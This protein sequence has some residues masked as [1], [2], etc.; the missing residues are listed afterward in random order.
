MNDT[1]D[2]HQLWSQLDAKIE[3]NWQLNLAL[4]KAG[5]LEKAARRLK[6]LVWVKASGLV[7]ALLFLAFVL[8]MAVLNWQVLS[9]ALAGLVLSI[10]TVAIIATTV[11][12]LILVRQIDFAA[13]V[14]SLQKDLSKLRLL[15]IRYLRIGL[16]IVPLHLAFII[17]FFYGININIISIAQPNWLIAQLVFSL[18][19]GLPFAYWA[20]FKLVPQNANKPWMNKLLLGNGSQVYDALAILE[21][22]KGLENPHE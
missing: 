10:W 19:I 1:P 2:I 4:V 7:V 3:R 20:H 21:E 17:S 14:M 8:R 16:W 6:Q 12:E 18:L 5:K 15:I 13:P 9:L 11:H 22:I